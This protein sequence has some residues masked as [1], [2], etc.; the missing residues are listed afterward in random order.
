[1]NF[2]KIFWGIMLTM[3][4]LIGNCSAAAAPRG[5]S[6]GTDDL[7][8]I[9]EWSLEK[10]GRVSKGKKVKYP[11]IAVEIE[12][13]Q[14]I[15]SI[16]S[17]LPEIQKIYLDGHELRYAPS[18]LRGDL[19]GDCCSFYVQVAKGKHTLKVKAKKHSAVSIKFKVKKSNMRDNLG[20][21]TKGQSPEEAAV[22]YFTLTLKKFGREL[23]LE[24]QYD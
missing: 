24:R 5:I 15:T 9:Q 18:N 12:S 7:E 16:F 22:Y 21:R 3:A 2:K 1:M 14:S 13:Y 8:N 19:K 20:N 4:L 23:E 11:W 6:E 10:T 17:D